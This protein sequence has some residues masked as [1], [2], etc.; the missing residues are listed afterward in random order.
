MRT[1]QILLVE[2]NPGDVL[3]VEQALEEYH[4]AYD[5]HV[6]RD[7]GEALVLIAGM[8]QK[9]GMPCPDVMLLDLNLPKVDGTQVLIEFRKHPR[10]EDT[11]VI[12]VTSSDAAKDRIKLKELGVTRYF[13]KPSDLDEFLRLGAMVRE[14]ADI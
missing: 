5:L 7:G 9:G 8:D 6:A 3:L 2:D 1:I 11:P 13:R 12:A 4:V 14:V 10:C